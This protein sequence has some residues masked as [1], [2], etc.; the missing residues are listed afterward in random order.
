[1]ILTEIINFKRRY[2]HHLY[3]NR[4]Y[5]VTSVKHLRAITM[6]SASI[7]D[8]GYG[9][10]SIVLIGDV[11]CP[12]TKRLVELCQHRMIFQSLDRSDYQ[13]LQCASACQVRN[14]P[15]E[16]QTN[17]FY[18]SFGRGV[19]I[20]EERPKPIQGVIGD[21]YCPGKYCLNREKC[22][23]PD[24]YVKTPRSLFGCGK[25]GVWLFLHKVPFKLQEHVKMT[26]T[27]KTGFFFAK[28]RWT[29]Y[30]TN[31]CF[32]MSHLSQPNLEGKNCV[33]TTKCKR[34]LEMCIVQHVEMKSVF[35]SQPIKR[36]VSTTVKS[37]KLKATFWIFLLRTKNW[38]L[39]CL[40]VM[41]HIV[42]QERRVATTKKKIHLR[43]WLN[44]P[45]ITTKHSLTWTWPKKA[46]VIPFM[47]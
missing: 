7:I 5:I 4:Y 27:D 38:Q 26:K 36:L 37:A 6:C 13:C 2:I 11:Y 22:E 33:W 24:G 9:N 14:I 44:P 39:C 43:F 35:T 15:F 1:M 34:L 18:L 28:K 30:P 41:V 8:C 19:H 23:S 17:A 10:S 16:D 42:F 12:N 31:S 20:F 47:P 25:C 45:P 46:E 40:A 32:L 29:W 21:V 3:K